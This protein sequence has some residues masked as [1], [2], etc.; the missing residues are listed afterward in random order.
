MGNESLTSDCKTDSVDIPPQLGFLRKAIEALSLGDSFFRELL[1]ALP[2]AI[3]ATDAAG[4]ISY[5]NEAAAK[6]WGWRPQLGT[7]EWCGSWKLYWPDGRPMPHGECPMAMAVKERRAI[8]GIEAIAERPDGSRVPFIPYPTPLFDSSGALVG[9]V[10]M[11]VDVTDRNRAEDYAQ[12]LV[13]IVESSNDAIVSKDLDGTITSWNRGAERLFGYT[14]EEA[15]GQPVIMIFPPDRLDEEVGIM[16]RIRRGERVEHFETVRRKKDGS[17]ID[18]SLTVSPV[19]DA[20]GRVIGASKIARDITESKRAREQQKLLLNEMK[21]RVKNSLLTVQAIALQTLP[22]ASESEREAFISRLHALARAHDLLTF[23]SWDG[24]ALG[25]VVAKVLEPFQEQHRERIVVNGPE[26]IWVG[27]TKSLSLAL[28][29]HELATNAI[30]YGA[31]SNGT[32]KVFIEWELSPEPKRVRLV[33]RE[34]GGPFVSQPSHTGFGSRLIL[35][36]VSSELGNAKIDYEA[37]G[38]T[39]AIDIGL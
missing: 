38:V 16:E 18:I 35:K 8:L 1:D 29:L 13:S 32:G 27:A 17:L 7:A 20:H 9:A 23:D 33:W 11:L 34:N 36:A 2:A 30:K 14:D 39:C 26:H 22:S 4:R 21:H 31:L 15:I 12:R 6:L 5:Y 19:K 37:A 3:Y 25:E 28:G 24:A 10:N